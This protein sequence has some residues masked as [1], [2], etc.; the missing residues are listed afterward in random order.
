MPWKVFFSAGEISGDISA[1]EIV[2]VLV[3]N[4]IECYGV[5][6]KYMLSKGLKPVVQSDESIKSSIGFVE[7]VKFVLPKFYLLN[8]IREYLRNNKVDLVVLVD[9]QGFNIH[10]AKVCKKMNIPVFYYIP[11]MVSV[12]GENT[13]YT[14]AK[15]CDKILC[16]F[17]EDYNVYREVTDKAE[18]VGSPIPERI[19]IN[20]S[21]R[22]NYLKDFSK[23]T[24]KV[25]LLFGSREQE[26]KTLTPPIL[27]FVKLF[28]DGILPI[29][30][31]LKNNTEFYTIV[32]HEAFKKYILDQIRK[33]N[34]ENYVKIYDNIGDYAIY[35]VCDFA[36]ASSGT[37]TLELALMGKPVVVVYKVSHLTFLIGKMLVKKKMISLPNIVLG[38]KFLPELIQKQVNPIIISEELFRFVSDPNYIQEINDNLKILREKINGGA[39]KNTSEIIMN[40]LKSS[41]LA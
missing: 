41:Y 17:E 20:Y 30:E 13:K 38:K 3:K 12:W 6:G 33:M 14:V 16:T 23:D 2:D 28:K 7:S 25:L 36:I 34:L 26:I 1:S 21:S 39:V 5:G 19:K 10:L 29:P 32:S 11:P 4:G 24:I 31:V 22:E 37:V 8:R 40:F 27:E 9:N 18:F 35:D 15:L